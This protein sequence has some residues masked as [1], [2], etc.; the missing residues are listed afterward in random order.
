[1]RRLFKG[2]RSKVPIVLRLYLLYSRLL[3]VIKA[4]MHLL[5]L[6]SL[7]LLLLLPLAVSDVNGHLHSLQHGVDFIGGQ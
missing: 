4:L 2:L 1:M 3:L 6:L 5:C 7:F